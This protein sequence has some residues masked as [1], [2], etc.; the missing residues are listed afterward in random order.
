MGGNIEFLIDVLTK[1][2]L[3]VYYELVRFHKCLSRLK[4]LINK[5]LIKRTVHLIITI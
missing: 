1:V 4:E 2:N 3:L 5:V